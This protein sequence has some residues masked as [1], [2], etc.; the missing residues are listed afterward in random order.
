MPAGTAA[1]FAPNEPDAPKISQV[2]APD[3]SSPPLRAIASL[4]R[5]P[6]PRDSLSRSHQRAYSQG[7]HTPQFFP[8]HVFVVATEAPS[9]TVTS[10]SQS[11]TS[12]P[13]KKSV[14]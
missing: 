3:T 8:S 10:S 1:P 12:T 5:R 6:S 2:S 11:A 7:L 14:A 13:P 4:A 9:A